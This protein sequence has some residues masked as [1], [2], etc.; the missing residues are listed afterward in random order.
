MLRPDSGS[1][2]LTQSD[3]ASAMNLHKANRSRFN[4]LEQK[5]QN[6]NLRTIAHNN[7][8]LYRAVQ[9]RVEDG[10]LEARE[11]SVGIHQSALEEDVAVTCASA[12]H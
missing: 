4:D 5:T 6:A 11:R 10:F 12:T 7:P 8:V 9:R 3:C 1:Y 2:V